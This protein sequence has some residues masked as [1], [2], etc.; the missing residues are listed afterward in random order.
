[1]P[2]NTVCV[3]RPGKWGNPFIVVRY[4]GTY[5]WKWEV[6][7]TRTLVDDNDPMVVGCHQ[8]KPQA[9]QS[10]IVLFL[11]ALGNGG[12]SVSIGDVI[13]RLR[14]KNLACF[15]PLGSPCHADVLLE[16]AN[17]GAA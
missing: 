12:L 3:T 2:E 14:G 1:M 5:P 13:E 9:V 17:G 16:I 4:D 7:D 10:A 15:C 11:R 6:R 8:T